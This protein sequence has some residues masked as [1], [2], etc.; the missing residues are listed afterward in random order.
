M[1]SAVQ[2]CWEKATRYLEVEEKFVNCTET[3]FTIDPIEAVSLCDENTIGAVAI[4]G[5]T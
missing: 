2:V 4:L 1:N 3:R 5:T